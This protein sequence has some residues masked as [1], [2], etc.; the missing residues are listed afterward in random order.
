MD[1]KRLRYFLIVAEE[2]SFTRAAARLHISQP[3]LSQMI[4][5]M[6]QEL[7]FK[8]FART[9]RRVALT[10]GGKVLVNDS[11]VVLKYAEEAIV[12]A[13]RA[14]NGETGHLRVAFIPWADFTTIFSEIFRHLRDVAPDVTVDFY[15]MPSLAAT[16]ALEEGRIDIAFMTQPRQPLS[17]VELELVLVDELVAALPK[18]HELSSRKVIPLRRLSMEPHIVVAP[19]RIIPRDS[20]VRTLYGENGY[21]LKARYMIDHPQTTLALVAAGVGISVVA[22][23]YQ[24]VERPGVVFRKISPTGHIR[25]I[26][27]WK[28]AN[29]TP[30]VK[31]FLRIL[32]KVVDRTKSKKRSV[33]R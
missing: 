27:A 1:L 28:S 18:G 9:K 8:L 10:E 6:E 5:R 30:A 23:S 33:R 19:D 7:G 4:A 22:S 16:Q 24:A 26:A 31:T 3:P 2:L 15:S 12:R 11:R 29:R 21:E 32:Y 25:L 17:G 13:R 14:A 20:P